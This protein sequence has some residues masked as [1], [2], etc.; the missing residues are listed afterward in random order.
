MH[1]T[2]AAHVHAAHE[3]AASS[4]WLDAT[5]F[6]SSTFVDFQYERDHLREVVFPELARRLRE[7]D[8]RAAVGMVDLRW[9]VDTL[10][11]GE[12]ANDADNSNDIA[13][14]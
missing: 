9:G 2:N 12:N 6:V 13:T 5:W 3:N 10:S 14:R 7:R 11:V 1:P 4:R 8:A